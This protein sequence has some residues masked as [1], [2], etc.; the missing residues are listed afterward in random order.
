MGLANRLFF[1][2]RPRQDHQMK[3]IVEP[4]TSTATGAFGAAAAAVSLALEGRKQW[5][6]HNQVRFETSQHNISCVLSQFPDSVVEDKRNGF[7]VASL[8][9]PMESPPVA[10]VPPAFVMPPRDFQLDNFERFKDKPCW[11]IFSEQGTGKTK[12]AWDIICHRALKGSVTGVIILSSPK[13]VHAQWIEEQMPKHLWPTVRVSAY[14]WDGKKPPSWLGKA[15]P[16]LQVV[17]GNIDMLKS[18]KGFTVLGIFANQHKGKL[19]VIVDESDSIKNISSVR[20]KKLRDLA[21]VTRQRGIMTGTPIAGDLTDEWAQFYFLDPDIIGHKYLTSFRA[22]YCVMGGFENRSVVGHRNVERFKALT[23]PHIFRAT[24]AMLDLPEKV[25][26]SVVFDLSPGQRKLIRELRDQFFS[27]LEQGPAVA[28]KT[29][30]VCLLRMQQISNGFAI[31]ENET[32]HTLD[33][34]RMDALLDLRRQISGQAIIWC[35][36]KE[37][38]RLVCRAIGPGAVTIY[39]EDNQQARAE[40]KESFLKGDAT[41]LVATPGAAGKGVDGLQKVCSTAIYYSNSYNAIDRWQSEDRIHRIGMGGTATYFDLIGRGSPDRAI[42]ANLKRKKDVA[43]LVLDD[44]KQI[45]E[46][47]E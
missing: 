32:M 9:D 22:Q 30:A 4:K 28:V 40:A 21:S 44:I 38:V 25:Y 43:S 33:N 37:D 34:P 31:D 7:R 24:K 6:A 41:D 35:R 26:D 29:G 20:S 10:T 13:G 17:S 18:G 2:S 23:A 36:F 12:V 14:V 27:D 47:I 19:L 42:L 11:A 16:E 46:S 5:V 15:T 3:I 8:L 45:M 39:G 1:S